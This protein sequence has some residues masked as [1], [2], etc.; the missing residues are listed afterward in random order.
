[1]LLGMW[2]TSRNWCHGQASLKK[3]G[4]GRSQGCSCYEFITTLAPVLKYSQRHKNLHMI[5]R[6]VRSIDIRV[7]HSHMLYCLRGILSF[8]FQSPLFHLCRLPFLRTL[9]WD[10]TSRCCLTVTT[11]D[12]F[13]RN[14]MSLSGTITRL[15]SVGQS[16]SCHKAVPAVRSHC[17]GVATHKNAAFVYG[18]LLPLQL[19]CLPCACGSL[20]GSAISGTWSNWTLVIFWRGITGFPPDQS[21]G[22]PCQMVT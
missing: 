14:H 7:T 10:T 11:T 13:W 17:S 21:P 9:L 3:S 1:M 22:L 18:L 16:Q 4:K 2:K 6:E 19:L 15:S 20:A 12:I 5:L 8:E